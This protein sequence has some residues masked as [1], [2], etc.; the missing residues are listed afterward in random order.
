MRVSL[1]LLLALACMPVTFARAQSAGSAYAVDYDQFYRIDLGTRK[2][3]L[4]GK[5]GG[6]GQLQ[7][8]DLSGLTTTPG[9]EVYVA[10]DTLKS[11]I[12]I[13]PGT[14]KGTVVGNFGINQNNSSDPLDFGMTAACD[15]SL[16]LNSAVTRQLWKVN[17]STAKAT[18]VG[19]MGHD[20][21]GMVAAHDSLYGVG[22][23]GDEGWYSI[24]TASGHASLLGS[25]GPAVTYITS[26]SPAV[27]SQGEVLAAFNYVPLPNNQP[28]PAWSDLARIDPVTGAATVLGTITGPP[29]LEDIGIRGFTLGPPAC[30]ATAPPT[31]D[32]VGAPTLGWWSRLLL[33]LLVGGLGTVLL[34]RKSTARDI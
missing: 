2:A 23:R 34:S 28:P 5:V 25:L 1:C 33:A 26:A 4:I 30:G 27:T 13:D 18:L 12:R 3:T 15:G 7:M 20:I 22:G 9:G 11:L 14:G 29:S 10:S 8:A 24:D 17:P 19:T 16:W 31:L 6:S 21:T 32:A